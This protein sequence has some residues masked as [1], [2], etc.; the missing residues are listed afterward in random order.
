MPWSPQPSR[1][2]RT[3]NATAGGLMA[4]LSAVVLAA[5][6]TGGCVFIQ[7]HTQF[8]PLHY[9]A[10]IGL[11][12]W[13]CGI[14]AVAAG[15]HRMARAAG[16]LLVVVAAVGA[17][18]NATV[19]G[20]GL[21]TWAFAEDRLLPAFPPGG[22]G[23][24]TAAA[25]LLGGVGLTL[26]ARRSRGTLDDVFLA[27]T[28]S[29]LLIG[30]A[31]VVV[32]SQLLFGSTQ[33]S[34]PPL[35]VCVAAVLGGLTV[36]ACSLRSAWAWFPIAR[37]IPVLVWSAGIAGSVVLWL[38]LDA[39]QNQRVRRDIQFDA[40]QTHQLLEHALTGWLQSLG[41]AAETVG[42]ERKAPQAA[43]DNVGMVFHSRP[44]TLGLGSVDADGH[45]RW[46]E[47][48]PNLRLPDRFSELGASAVLARPVEAGVAG[49]TL[50]QRSL[51]D[52]KW[53]LVGYAPVRPGSAQHGGLVGV[54]EVQTLLESVLTTQVA[55]G[56]AV[57]VWE[58]NER[59]FGRMNTD[60][61]FKSEY[62]EPLSLR[63][64]KQQWVLWVWPTEV[65]LK[66]ETLSLPRLSL[67]V[68]FVLVTLFSLAIFLAQM[69][70]GRAKTLENEVHERVMVEAALRQTEGDL[71]E[72]KVAAENASRLK[73]EFLANMSHEIRTPMNGILGMTELALDTDL[74][75]E[76][77]EYLETVRTSANSLLTVINDILDFSKIEAGKLDLDPHDFHL[78]DAL[79]D[80]MNGLAVRA[81]KKGLELA[82]HID[83]DIPDVLVG[84][85][86]RL[87]QVMIN[88][89]GNA[90]KFTD[91]GEVVVSV[92]MEE[93]GADEIH[94]R[95][96][97]RDTGIGIPKAKQA[98]VFES[99]T[100]AD[101][102][103][104]RRFGGTGLG[105]A[106][107][108][109]LVA[110]MGGRIGVVSEPAAGSTFYFTA[111]FGRTTGQALK[112]LS[113]RVDLEGLPVLVVDDNATNRGILQEVLTNWRMAPT[114]VASGA[115]ALAD[116]RRTSAEGVPYPLVLIDALM[117]DMDGFAVVE[118][119][120]KDPTL[121]GATILMLSS[122][123]RAADLARCR[124][125]GI[126]FYLVKPIRQS[127][128]L[129]AILTALG[130]APLGN[131]DVAPTLSDPAVAPGHGL[132]VLLAEDNEV[133]QVLAIKMLQKRGHTVT[134]AE[135]GR[136]AV[137]ALE[138]QVFDIVLM[139]VQMPE[140]DG[141]EA[142]AAIRESEKG[143]GRHIPIVALTAHAMKGD[144]ERCLAAGMDDYI[145]K[146]L[147][148]D[149]LHITLARLTAGAAESEP[150]AVDRE[151]LT[152]P[153]FD[154]TAVL[155][156]LE[157]DME[158]LQEMI[159]LF[160]P[161]S[162][163]L[164][165][166]I[167]AAVA[168]AD[169]TRLEQSAHNLKG[170]LGNFGARGACNAARQLEIIGHGGNWAGAEVACDDLE[171]EVVRLRKALGDVSKEC[172]ECVS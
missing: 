23:S 59:V 101:G 62:A 33:F 5:W 85:A 110:L 3:A 91:R 73:S 114:A 42:T 146:P 137:A 12:V 76:Q 149:D 102:S 29:A 170:S 51:W 39:Q 144:R 78:R 166:E 64:A 84:D 156:R 117:P 157:G 36:L 57:E 9:N 44:G 17:F 81:H 151:R 77:R 80:M 103:T 11:F 25:F 27:L 82:C 90:I 21:N 155:A 108:S 49:V 106:I 45:V 37:A 147:R 40:A 120:R 55:S 167:R 22:V 152:E 86:M 164:L 74:S 116:M 118:E 130:S 38:A 111:P 16:G 24:A 143:T 97:V 56:Y 7:L 126:A 145:S 48:K 121:A 75:P 93:R 54:I 32:N 60:T 4:I 47:T 141:F 104:T 52:G 165:T 112:P 65:A 34:G 31:A 18:C 163:K 61:R 92:V 20:F 2:F 58:G 69:A 63:A 30:T 13:G 158:L 172:S 160:S 138:T 68:G 14:V 122:G 125:L 96:A 26:M 133:N 88:L 15:Y 113:Q 135:N 6:S 127:E 109:Q 123:D 100:Q 94:L 50:A 148:A 19:Q 159:H 119:V 142:T 99:F 46:L 1:L 131:P 140:M 87:Q 105:L 72:A 35:L 95:F 128:L 67:G 28:G 153:V 8:D 10:A 98:A 124:E 136:L 132:R 129:D 107:S 70:R 66:R 139:D 162:V 41:T 171:Q 79:G 71:R 53:V 89:I 134:V 161:Q 115:L 83:L 154:R 43:I 169:G 168:A 150:P